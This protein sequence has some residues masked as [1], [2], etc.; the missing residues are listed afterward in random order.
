[1]K[2]ALIKLFIIV[3]IGSIAFAFAETATV[4]QTTNIKWTPGKAT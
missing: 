2:K 1:M 3:L 4:N